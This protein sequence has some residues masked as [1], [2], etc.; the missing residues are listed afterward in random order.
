MTTHTLLPL[1]NDPYFTYT[2]TL[3]SVGV[4]L[5]FEYN[6]RSKHFHISLYLRDGTAVMVGRKLIATTL[7]F[8]PAMEAVGLSGGFIITPILLSIEETEDT[9]LNVADNYYLAYVA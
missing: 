3:G 9:M 6:N 8:N 2:T 4:K 7:I 5:V 1:F